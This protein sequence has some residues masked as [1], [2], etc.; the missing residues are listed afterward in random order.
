M[1]LSN[2]F[3]MRNLNNFLGSKTPWLQNT[4]LSVVE[5]LECNF[6]FVNRDQPG[7]NMKSL[8]D[9]HGT[10]KRFC[11]DQNWTIAE[12][13]DTNL[14]IFL[15]SLPETKEIRDLMIFAKDLWSDFHRETVP[16]YTLKY[17]VLRMLIQG[18]ITVEFV[19]V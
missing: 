8:I 11:G 18:G 5:L 15:N 10:N 17:L 7:K 6:S 12:K 13:P 14:L 4:N 9:S 16:C 1:K 3:K 19:A 2:C